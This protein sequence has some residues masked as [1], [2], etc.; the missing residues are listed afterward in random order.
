[1][2][3]ALALFELLKE[4]EIYDLTGLDEEIK[5]LKNNIYENS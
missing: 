4:N 5:Q 1:M 3:L 2:E